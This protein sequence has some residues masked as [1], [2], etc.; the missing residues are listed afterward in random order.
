[1]SPLTLLELTFP[2]WYSSWTSRFQITPQHLWPGV[3]CVDI[4]WKWLS[5]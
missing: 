1:M 3:S 4:Q 2:L 5:A